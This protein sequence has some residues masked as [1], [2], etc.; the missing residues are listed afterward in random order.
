MYV[1]VNGSYVGYSQGSK[2]PAKFN[3]TPYVKGGENLIALQMFRWSD[4]SYLESQDMLRMSGIERD[5]YLYTRPKV[6]ISDYNAWADLDDSYSDGIFKGTVAVTNSSNTAV[7]RNIS[8][9]LLNGDTSI[10]KAIKKLEIKSNVTKEFKVNEFLKNA[11]QW[12]AE[13]PNLYELKIVLEDLDDPNNNEYSSIDWPESHPSVCYVWGHADH[14]M[15]FFWSDSPQYC[16]Q[17]KTANGN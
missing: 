5:V 8:M 16:R 17:Y 11:K 2:T 12:S 9:E 7:I 6:F 14:S 13:I 1:Y 3:I 15:P 4:A 10:Y